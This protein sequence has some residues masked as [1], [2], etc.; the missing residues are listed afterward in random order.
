M[1]AAPVGF[2]SEQKEERSVRL[3]AFVFV[4][5]QLVQLVLKEGNRHGAT[6]ASVR[7]RLGLEGE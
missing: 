1:A 3:S 5:M 7:Q 4:Q 6:S 2:L